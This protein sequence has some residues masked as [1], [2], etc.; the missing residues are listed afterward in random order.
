MRA[1][2]RQEVDEPYSESQARWDNEQKRDDRQEGGCDDAIQPM[3]PRACD[4][5]YALRAVV[6]GM[7]RPQE[8]HRVLDTM[9]PVAKEI[10]SAPKDNI[11]QRPSVRRWM[12]PPPIARM[13]AAAHA[14]VRGS[15]SFARKRFV[16]VTFQSQNTARSFHS[17]GRRRSI[18]RMSNPS[19]VSPLSATTIVSTVFMGQ[20][21]MV[22]AAEGLLRA[23][24]RNGNS[25]EKP[26]CWTVTVRLFAPAVIVV[27]GVRPPT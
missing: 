15:A 12:S 26:V 2:I 4:E 3:M 13:I 27:V 9:V 7:Q 1:A 20:N 14:A 17:I 23:V 21:G 18:W 6:K 25:I 10:A 8:R 19:H 11:Y 5:R 16:R 22:A 24:R